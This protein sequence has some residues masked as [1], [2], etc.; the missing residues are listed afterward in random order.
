MSLLHTLFIRTIISREILLFCV[1]IGIIHRFNQ[2]IMMYASRFLLCCQV[3]PLDNLLNQL[4]VVV[5]HFRASHDR[6]CRGLRR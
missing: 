1:Q 4:D 2:L 6:Y 5:I 3:L